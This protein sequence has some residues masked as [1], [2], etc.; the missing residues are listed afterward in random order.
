MTCPIDVTNHCSLGLVEN[1]AGLLRRLNVLS[2]KECDNVF[3]ICSSVCF[4]YKTCDTNCDYNYYKEYE[5][6]GLHGARGR[7]DR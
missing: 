1:L 7:V 6:V 3:D 2:E 4:T 5:V